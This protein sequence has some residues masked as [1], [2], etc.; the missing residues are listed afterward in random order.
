MN[1]H[2]RSFDASNEEAVKKVVDDAVATYGQLDVFFANAGIVGSVTQPVTDIP[3]DQF[4]WTLKIN[5]S[6]C[7]GRRVW[8]W[9]WWWVDGSNGLQR[10]LG[11]QACV[12]GDED[13]ECHQE[14]VGRVD[15]RDRL[16]RGY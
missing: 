13:Y 16:N 14:S 10:V 5:V 6:R 8:W 2:A 12:P 15:Y 11:C 7:V 9:W 1:V 3:L 4:M